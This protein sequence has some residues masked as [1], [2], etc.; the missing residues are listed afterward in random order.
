MCAWLGKKIIQWTRMNSPPIALSI[1]QSPPQLVV[2][3]ISCPCLIGM[4]VGWRLGQGLWL[5]CWETFQVVS[6]FIGKVKHDDFTSENNWELNKLPRR[7]PHCQTAGVRKLYIKLNAES[8]IKMQVL[9]NF[10]LGWLLILSS[11]YA[12]IF[13][14]PRPS[15]LKYWPWIGGNLVSDVCECFYVGFISLFVML[16]FHLHPFAHVPAPS[17]E[18]KFYIYLYWLK[19]LAD[20]CG[21]LC[22]PLL[23]SLQIRRNQTSPEKLDRFSVA[24]K[25]NRDFRNLGCQ[26][27]RI[28]LDVIVF[29]KFVYVGYKAFIVTL[30]FA[31]WTPTDLSLCFPYVVHCLNGC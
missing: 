4:I 7:L 15:N 12:L 13:T 24:K 30:H 28:L 25:M 21:G 11:F 22:W 26:N 17:F 5:D 10:F 19:C 27:A 3:A 18:I 6:S 14:W 23:Y 1:P 2:L 20:L 16:R 9:C 8:T 29:Q 31:H